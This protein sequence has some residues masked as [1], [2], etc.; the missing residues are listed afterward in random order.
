MA[1]KT[2][3]DSP[4]YHSENKGCVLVDHKKF[5]KRWKYKATRKDCSKKEYTEYLLEKKCLTHNIVICRCGWQRKFHQAEDSAY[6]SQQTE[7]WR[8]NHA[9]IRTK[10]IT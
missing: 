1:K 4:Y 5:V 10:K 3:Y 2:I 6:I 8:K 7:A 9:P